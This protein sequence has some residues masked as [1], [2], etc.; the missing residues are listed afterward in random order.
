MYLKMKKI[1]VLVIA[2]SL[3]VA[4][5]SNEKKK[6]NQS[7]QKQTVQI[8]S[9]QKIK[10]KPGEEGP[11]GPGQGPEDRPERPTIEEL[12]ADLDTNDDGKLSKSEA[13]GPL[14]NEFS[15]IDTNNDGY[16]VV[17]EL[18]NMPKPEGRPNDKH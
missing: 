9:K 15:S 7:D 14:K 13:R 12:L 6:E 5:G 10:Q 8:E 11:D 16:L 18:K 1:G 4:C 2:L 3:F 17:D